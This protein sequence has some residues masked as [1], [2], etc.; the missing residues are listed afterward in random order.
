MDWPPSENTVFSTY[1]LLFLLKSELHGRAEP[2]QEPATYGAK[3]I[4]A[5]RSIKI[6]FAVL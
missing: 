6:I 1:F 3:R 4:G 5:N 2:W